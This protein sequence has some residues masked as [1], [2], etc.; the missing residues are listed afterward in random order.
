MPHTWVAV[1]DCG[2]LAAWNKRQQWQRQQQQ[3]ML[4]CGSIYT[5]ELIQHELRG[6]VAVGQE[7]AP[8]Q[9][10]TGEVGV[11]DTFIQKGNPFAADASAN[12]HAS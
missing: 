10:Q 9:N 5:A 11:F 12:A 1:Y 2:A 6:A 3:L 8:M 4:W 7:E